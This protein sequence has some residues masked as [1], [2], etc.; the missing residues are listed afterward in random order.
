MKE[1]NDFTL[2]FE[3]TDPFQSVKE[4]QK[5]S[6][7]IY[8]CIIILITIYLSTIYFFNNFKLII[9][10]ISI[11]LLSTYIALKLLFIKK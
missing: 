9:T 5:N 10:F 11:F 8:V 3:E 6:F 7:S 2:L 4:E 1:V